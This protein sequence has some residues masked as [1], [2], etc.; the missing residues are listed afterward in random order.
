VALGLA[1][2]EASARAMV[3]AGVIVA[4]ALLAAAARS[5]SVDLPSPSGLVDAQL[6]ERGPARAAALF[7]SMEKWVVDAAIGAAV[8]ALRLCS[9]TIHRADVR[10]VSRPG[11]AV[12]AS[13]LRAARRVETWVGRPLGR[14]AWALVGL[15][16][17]A[18]L[19]HALWPGK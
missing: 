14:A 12:A 15:L 10:V 2:V 5:P 1:G 9:W 8:G 11:D 13:A 17:V 18:A 7:V 3:A 6:F 19:A 16:V 4:G